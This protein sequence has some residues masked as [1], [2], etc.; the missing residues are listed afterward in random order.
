MTVRTTDGRLELSTVRWG[1]LVGFVGCL[2]LAIYAA[3][4]LLNSYGAETSSFTNYLVGL[5]FVPGVL[6]TALILPLGA[7]VY[8]R[9]LV[10]H[11]DRRVV[12]IEET[13]L[14]RTSVREV[15]FDDCQD[16]EWE[17]GA[18]WLVNQDYFALWL[19]DGEMI[20]VS[21]VNARRNQEWRR[22]WDWLVL[23]WAPRL[24]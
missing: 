6:A 11:L 2:N 4:L 23:N 1:V 8:R 19:K 18:V 12:W 15:S 7:A 13:S 21:R 17:E 10:F 22:A 3:C 20:P 16:I 5:L 24:K 14:M 9:R